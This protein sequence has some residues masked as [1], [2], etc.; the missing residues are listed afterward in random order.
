MGKEREVVLLAVDVCR[1]V[2]LWCV[3]ALWSRPSRRPLGMT[4]RHR[5]RGYAIGARGLNYDAL[6]YAQNFDDG[7]LGECETETDFTSRFAP[8][9]LTGGRRPSADHFCP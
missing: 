2:A 9:R 1:S 4:R 6:S 5:R 3:S 8:A 7:G